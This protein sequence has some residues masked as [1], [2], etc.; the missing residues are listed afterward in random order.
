MDILLLLIHIIFFLNSVSNKIINMF[1]LKKGLKKF[2]MYV[3][4][5]KS[6]FVTNSNYF[7]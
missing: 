5:R 7:N 3:E 4:A 2:E 6:E 1:S